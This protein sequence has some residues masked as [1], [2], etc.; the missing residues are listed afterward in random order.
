[1]KKP[2]TSKRFQNF[3]KN[4]A[5]SVL[6]GDTYSDDYGYD[7]FV[8]DQKK[9]FK[10]AILVSDFFDWTRSEDIDMSFRR[11][12]YEMEDFR[13]QK[14]SHDQRLFKTIHGVDF[15]SKEHV[16]IPSYKIDGMSITW[17]D[18]N[19]NLVELYCNYNSFD[20][21]IEDNK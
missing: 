17:D 1:M 21:L 16:L 8:N 2:T 10:K 20:I 6:Q 7:N 14:E 13:K 19:E 3:I 5:F 9:N 12:D 18:E 15:N 11:K 4:K